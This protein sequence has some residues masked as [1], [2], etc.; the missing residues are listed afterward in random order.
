MYRCTRLCLSKYLRI[1]SGISFILGQII[2]GLWVY[3]LVPSNFPLV[4]AHNRQVCVAA[5]GHA[6]CAQR[7]RQGASQSDPSQRSRCLAYRGLVMLA[8]SLSLSLS[9]CRSLSLSLSI[10]VVLL[11][12][13]HTP[14]A[15]CLPKTRRRHA[16]PFRPLMRC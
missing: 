4:F 1:M 16:A 7:F 13:R 15:D 14:R 11:F 2:W 6:V 9:V 10:S 3:V 8:L 12:L 5:A